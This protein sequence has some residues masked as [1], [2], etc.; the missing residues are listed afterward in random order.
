MG[1]IEI[2]RSRFKQSKNSSLITRIYV[3]G[4]FVNF[5]VIFGYVW[6]ETV[7][8]K[9]AIQDDGLSN[10]RWNIQRPPAQDTPAMQ[11]K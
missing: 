4:C 8:L 5:W 10:T 7:F 3:M 6:E 9:V 11:A 2:S 1:L